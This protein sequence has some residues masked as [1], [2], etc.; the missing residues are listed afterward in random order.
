VREQADLVNGPI[1]SDE[2]VWP[3]ISLRAKIGK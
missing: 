3:V 2:K 1:G